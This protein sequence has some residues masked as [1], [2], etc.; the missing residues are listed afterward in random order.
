MFESMFMLYAA[1]ILL[2]FVMGVLVGM[3]Y[4]YRNAVREIARR[5]EPPMEELLKK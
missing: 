5:I 4:G 2:G 1:F 3:I